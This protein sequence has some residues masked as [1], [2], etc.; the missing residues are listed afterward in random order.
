MTSPIAAMRHGLGNVSF[1]A[2]VF[3]R[4]VVSSRLTEPSPLVELLCLHAHV[5][6]RHVLSVHVRPHKCPHCNTQG[7][8]LPKDLQRHLRTQHP[9]IYRA[10]TYCCTHSGC[11]IFNQPMFRGRRDNYQK[12]MRSHQ[13]N[14][15]TPE[16]S[17]SSFT[18][19]PSTT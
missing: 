15:A 10:K 3:T 13:A 8:G 17:S 18:S 11:A 14:V 12:H 2:G 1:V 19:S 16:A 6:R 4:D 7:F 9:Q 5:C